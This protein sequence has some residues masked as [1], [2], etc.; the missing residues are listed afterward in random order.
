MIRFYLRRS[1]YIQ[2]VRGKQTHFMKRLNL[3]SSGLI[4]AIIGVASA[5]T[6]WGA[7]AACT[8]GTAFPTQPPAIGG[9]TTP[10]AGTINAPDAG[11]AAGCTA[12]DDLFSNFSTNA[13]TGANAYTF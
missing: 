13:S 2:P 4:V 11:F 8:S 9:T 1:G 10:A 12:V 7:N 3:G 6:G 5:N